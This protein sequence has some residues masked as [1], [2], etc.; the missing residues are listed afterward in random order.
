[1]GGGGWAQV[2]AIAV[3]ALFNLLLAAAA[4]RL[5]KYQRHR[6]VGGQEDAVAFAVFV[7]Q[8]VNTFLVRVCARRPLGARVF[9]CLCVL[10]CACACARA[11]AQG[12]ACVCVCVCV[13]VSCPFV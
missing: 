10:K 3:V 9:V 1:M 2:G 13:C 8:F 12:C 7:G 6:T 4:T 11:R 5:A